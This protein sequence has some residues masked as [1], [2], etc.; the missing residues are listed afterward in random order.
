MESSTQTTPVIRRPIVWLLAILVI[1]LAVRVWRLSEP[2]QLDEFGVIY[3]VAERPVGSPDAPV[4]SDVPLGPVSSLAEVRARSVLPFGIP[5]PVPLYQY[6]V[7]GTL[8]VLPAAEWSMRLPSLLAGLG[9]VVGLYFLCRWLLGSEVA[10]VAALIAAVDPIQVATSD[11]A[12]PFAL[13]NLACLLSFIALLGALKARHAGN[14]V[15]A[16]LGYGVAMAVIGYLSPALILVVTAH[17]GLVVYWAVSRPGGAAGLVYW[18][19]GCAVGAALLIPEFP[20]FRQLWAFN[21]DHRDYLAAMDGYEWIHLFLE[22]NL[23][24]LAALL[25]IWIAAYIVRQQRQEKV[26]AT[27]GAEATRT[28]STG[29]PSTAVDA[30]GM[31]P[32]TGSGLGVKTA[33]EQPPPPDN[34][35]LPWVGRLWLFVP[36][37]AVVIAAFTLSPEFMTTRS[38]TYVTLGGAVILAY[39]ATRERSREVRLGI[40]AA[41]VVTT[42]LVSFLAYSQGHNLYTQSSAKN[43]VAHLDMLQSCQPGDVV[44]YRPKLLEADLLPDIPE[45][46]QRYVKAALAAPLKTLYAPA[47]PLEVIVLSRS[48]RSERTRPFAPPSFKPERI[49]TEQLAEKIRGNKQQFWV[50]NDGAFPYFDRFLT[51][52]LPWM[53]NTLECDLKVARDRDVKSGE[54]YFTVQCDD[55]PSDMLEGLVNSRPTDFA[56]A[57]LIRVQR[58]YP[59]R[60]VYYTGLGALTVA[61][62]ANVGNATAAAWLAIQDRTPR[63]ASRPPS[64]E[65]PGQGEAPKQ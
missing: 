40:S 22:T 59:R 20:Y 3:A 50:A 12:Q 11:M 55:Q 47:K 25:V 23:A 61:G 56:K 65:K 31:A 53:A 8:K 13:A 37:L 34:P 6:L 19:I 16:A 42:F 39:W 9:C 48:H 24:F 63:L 46:S 4:T 62:E 29:E 21:T 35:D 45:E 17:L 5:N 49:Y 43:M 58:L 36:Q 64:G 32:T 15:L 2:L 44:L 7:Y 1:A 14:A 51:C 54:R 57:D 10:V 38:L 18:V 60:E 28:A 27:Q 26:Q 41:A 33:L 52:L 30:P